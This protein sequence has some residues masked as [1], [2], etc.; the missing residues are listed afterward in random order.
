MNNWIPE[1][2]SSTELVLLTVE[3]ES[4]LGGDLIDALP[5][6]YDYNTKIQLLLITKRL[7]KNNVTTR[8]Y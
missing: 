7:I 6:D 1:H 4:G 8:S 3:K 2:Q 5:K